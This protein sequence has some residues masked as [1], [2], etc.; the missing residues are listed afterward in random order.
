MKNCWAKPNGPLVKSRNSWVRA[1]RSCKTGGLR[2]RSFG[3]PPRGIRGAMNASR[4]HLR[5]PL[6]GKRLL[7]R[8]QISSALRRSPSRTNLQP[9]WPQATVRINRT[10]TPRLP[11]SKAAATAAAA[12]TTKAKVHRL[13]QDSSV[14]MRRPGLVSATGKSLGLGSEDRQRECGC[15]IKPWVWLAASENAYMHWCWVSTSVW[16]EPGKKHPCSSKL[17]LQAIQDPGPLLQPLLQL[18]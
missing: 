15:S 5:S 16:S 9:R 13:R 10:Q 3:G 17:P 1:A 7:P 14:L 11:V 6:W 18:F 4:H 2:L 8:M 12:A